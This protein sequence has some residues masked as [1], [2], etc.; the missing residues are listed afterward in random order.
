M[1]VNVLTIISE[2][3]LKLKVFYNEKQNN[4]TD[5]DDPS[6]SNWDFILVL[7]ALNVLPLPRFIIFYPFLVVVD[8]HVVPCSLPFK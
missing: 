8:S 5:L 2:K 7:K 4:L 6:N 3:Q 1:Y